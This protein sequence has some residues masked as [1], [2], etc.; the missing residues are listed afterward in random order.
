MEEMYLKT[1]LKVWE[2]TTKFWLK[3]FALLSWIIVRLK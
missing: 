3:I 2:D 1:K